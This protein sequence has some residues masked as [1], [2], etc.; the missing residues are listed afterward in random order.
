MQREGN[1]SENISVSSLQLN[2]PGAQ[3]YLNQ[4]NSP[5]PKYFLLILKGYD[6]G[7]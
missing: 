4:I 7:V 3:I 5:L 2:R 1:E 6:D